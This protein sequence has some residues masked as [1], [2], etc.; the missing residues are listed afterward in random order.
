LAQLL[1]AYPWAAWL[2]SGIVHGGAFL[3]IMLMVTGS[4]QDRLMALI[5]AGDGPPLE[6]MNLDELAP[7]DDIAVPGQAGQASLGPVTEGDGIELPGPFTGTVGNVQTGTTNAGGLSPSSADAV[8]DPFATGEFAGGDFTAGLAALSNPL[9]T[10]GGGLEGRKFEN[11]LAAALAGGGTRE[12]EQAV[13]LGLAWLAAHQFADG[14][15]RFTLEEHPDCAGACRDQGTYTTTT[16]ATGLALLSFLGAGYTHRDGNYAEAV[17]R[18]L[19]YLDQKM[20]RTSRGGDLRDNDEELNEGFV[21][22]LRRRPQRGGWRRDTMYSHGIATI[23]LTEA[24]AMTGDLSL[25]KNAQDA[26]TFIINAQYD[27][28]G[29]RYE[30]RGE[31]YGPGDVTVTGWQLAAL[32]SAML[33]GI[34]VPYDV[35]TRASQFL[36]SQQ[37]DGGSAYAYTQGQRGTRATTAIGLL[38]RMI[39][40]WPRDAK[41]LLKGVVRLGG[42]TPQGNTMYYNYYASQ[43]LHHVGGARWERWNPRMREYLVESQA[44]AG[45]ERGSWYFDEQHSQEGGR[46]YTTAMA[47]MTLEVYYRYMPLYG[48]SFVAKGP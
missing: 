2:T 12:S 23:A 21:G 18:G 6:E 3:V 41:P 25:R 43:V 35:W 14:S 31:S 26:A 36:D 10:R 15:W 29:W 7:I 42:E 20:I 30:P 9:A 32:K 45:H 48:E 5:G 27:D 44:T 46:L 37:M 13:E 40:G 16:A 39:G 28:G 4:P 47:V 33:A 24:Y 34:E 38:C 1:D 17:S 8:L 11:R 22:G 19:Y